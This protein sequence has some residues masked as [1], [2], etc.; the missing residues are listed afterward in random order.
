MIFSHLVICGWRPTRERLSIEEALELRRLLQELQILGVMA[1]ATVPLV[2]DF[3]S[4][5]RRG[6]C[7]AAIHVASRTAKQGDAENRAQAE[8]QC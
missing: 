4:G 3:A 7:R 5:F 8:H 2:D 1:G 6:K